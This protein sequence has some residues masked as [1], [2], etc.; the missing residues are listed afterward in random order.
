MTLHPEIAEALNEHVS[1]EARS[2]FTY[3]SM[4][5]WAEVQ[6]LSGMAAWFRSEA[7]GEMAHMRQFMDH[8]NDRGYQTT[9]AALPQPRS[10]WSNAISA[11]E[12]V[13]RLESE[14]C[15]R[16]DQLIELSHSRRDHFTG[17]FLQGFV[18]QQIADMAEADEILD[19]LRIVG[20]DG[21]GVILIDQELRAKAGGA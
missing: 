12:D 20:D 11:F 21:Q 14:L 13:V 3:F 15:E 7:D 16:I 5:S 6:G 1:L 17:S 9:F 19:R 2:A 4:A 10:E 18:P 8:L